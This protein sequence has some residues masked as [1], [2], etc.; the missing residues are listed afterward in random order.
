MPVRLKT[1]RLW[2]VVAIVLVITGAVAVAGTGS[3][4]APP[5]RLPLSRAI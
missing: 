2:S 4:T 5:H 3:D 1:A